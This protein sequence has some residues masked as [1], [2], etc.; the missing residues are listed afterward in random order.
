MIPPDCNLSPPFI[1]IFGASS[2]KKTDNKE[3]RKGCALVLIQRI[4]MLV[5]SLYPI[6]KTSAL[7]VDESV[8]LEKNLCN[9]TS[10]NNIFLK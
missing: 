4:M 1:M 8:L 5:A 3:K 7:S 10:F 9:V 6:I 2:N